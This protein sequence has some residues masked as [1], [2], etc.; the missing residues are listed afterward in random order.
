M[1]PSRRAALRIATRAATC[2]GKKRVAEQ[3]SPHLTSKRSRPHSWLHDSECQVYHGASGAQQLLSSAHCR[4]ASYPC[5]AHS[6]QPAQPQ[7][8]PAACS[9][10]RNRT[11]TSS[12]THPL[13]P[14]AL[15]APRGAAE[16]GA[17][18]PRHALQQHAQRG[19]V[20]GERQRQEVVRHVGAQ[21][22]VRRR[23]RRQQ[24]RQPRLAP[25]RRARRVAACARAGPGR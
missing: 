23:Q 9:L 13:R 10:G 16:L 17:R 11:S 8:A 1:R 14:C 24:R 3:L 6:T 5:S 7:S 2:G 15:L 4:H 12:R 19:R 22:R 20:H 18:G 21:P 25:L